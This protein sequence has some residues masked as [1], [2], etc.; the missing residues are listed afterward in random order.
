[1]ALARIFSYS[2]EQAAALIQDLQRQGYQVEVLRPE[3]TP[4][5]PADLEIQYELCEAD[6]AVERA[7]ELASEFQTDIAV[8]SGA[9]PLAA[10]ESEVPETLPTVET[11]VPE[12]MAME[13][14]SPASPIIHDSVEEV[15][16][17]EEPR[18]EQETTPEDAPG[19]Q[20][21]ESPVPK[22]VIAASTTGTTPMQPPVP[23]IWSRSATAL[24]AWAGNSLESMHA[25][26]LAGLHRMREQRE[27]AAIR[28][29]EIRAQR[30]QRL[31][32][33]TCRRAEALQRT[34]QIEA[35]RRAAGGYLSQLQRESATATPAEALGTV[36][37]APASL[38]ENEKSAIAWWTPSQHVKSIAAGA[39]AAGAL[40]AL[41]L[42]ISA[43]RSKPTPAPAKTTAAP[44]EPPQPQVTLQSN[45]VMTHESLKVS[46]VHKDQPK[47]ASSTARVVLHAPVSTPEDDSV[48]DDVV[49][50]HFSSPSPQKLESKVSADVK[51]YSDTDN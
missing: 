22:P 15:W 21:I 39:A 46:P 47:P 31:L 44:V 37:P 19:Y 2:P 17:A 40:F 12:T 48:A 50:R 6:R 7:Q 34:R 43:L 35:A 5:G 41:T 26:W 51:R 1:M 28:A 25:L 18:R 20:E 13:A 30:E 42:G 11:D 14:G 36:V 45:S 33:L 49:V 23:G 29:T 8:E 9:L 24:I 10:A 38:R 4:S 3:E 16:M 32:E 27:R